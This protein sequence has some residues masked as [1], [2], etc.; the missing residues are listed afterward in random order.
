MQ[1][2]VLASS[3]ALLPTSITPTRGMSA[4]TR[5][6]MYTLSQ[7]SIGT[8]KFARHHK[9]RKTRFSALQNNNSQ[10]EKTVQGSWYLL[11]IVW[12]KLVVVMLLEPEREREKLTC[13]V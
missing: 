12:S 2:K 13:P 11:L 10:S 9:F 6:I 5:A 3:G 8:F 4:C 7:C 1:N